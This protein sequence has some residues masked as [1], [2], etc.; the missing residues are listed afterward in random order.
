MGNTV[1][2]LSLA[3]TGAK[4]EHASIEEAVQACAIATGRS[5]WDVCRDNIVNVYHTATRGIDVQT[6]AS[7]SYTVLGNIRSEVRYV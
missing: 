7:R 6:L 3:S 1:F 2:V 5:R 4:S